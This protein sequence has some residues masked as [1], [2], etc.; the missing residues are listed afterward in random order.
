MTNQYNAR[1]QQHTLKSL[2][3]AQGLKNA[4]RPQFFVIHKDTK[5]FAVYIM[6]DW[7]RD[8]VLQI[9]LLTLSSTFYSRFP[10]HLPNESYF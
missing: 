4:A 7:T 5:Q 2:K 9:N 6:E 8:P 1:K 10:L 3:D